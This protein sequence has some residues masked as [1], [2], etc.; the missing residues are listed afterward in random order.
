MFKDQDDKL[1][2]F[3]DFN[4][5]D[6]EETEGS[7][8]LNSEDLIEETTEDMLLDQD[9]LETE[10]VDGNEFSNSIESDSEESDLIYEDTEEFSE[11]SDD[12]ESA[13]VGIPEALKRDSED[14]EE[15]DDKKSKKKKNK[16]KKEKKKKKV[17][18]KSKVSKLSK[19]NFIAKYL[20]VMKTNKDDSDLGLGRNSIK[21]QIMTITS[22]AIIVPMVLIAIVVFLQ[23][24]NSNQN[25]IETSASV[26]VYQASDLIDE[27][28]ASMMNILPQTFRELSAAPEQYGILT[29]V[30]TDVLRRTKNSSP[31]IYEAYLVSHEDYV[32]SSS[33][34]NMKASDELLS[35]DWF[36][37]ARNKTQTIWSPVYEDGKLKYR[38]TSKVTNSIGQSLFVLEIDM[39][40]L[41]TFAENIQVLEEG[42]AIVASREGLILYHPNAELIGQTLPES[43]YEKM[44]IRKEYVNPAMRDD[45]GVKSSHV[46]QYKW[47]LEGSDDRILTYTQN[48]GVEWVIMTTFEKSEIIA[49]IRPIF[50]AIA[51]VI[52]LVLFIFLSLG[53]LVANRITS[54]ISQLIGIMKQVEDGDLSVEFETSAKSEVKILGNSFNVMILNLRT[55]VGSMKNTFGNVEDFVNTLTTA[56]EQTSLASEEISKS[57]ISVAEGAETQADK[58]NESV[59]MIND[60]DEKILAVNDSAQEIKVSSSDAIELN[61]E[62]ISLV[63]DLKDISE[64]N[65]EKAEH[66]IT[67]MDTLSGRVAKIS[68][69]ISLINNISRQ[70]NLL[71][72]NAS[73]E[74]ARAGEHGRGFAVVANEVSKLAEE[75]SQAVQGIGSLLN[76]I[77]EDVNKASSAID[78][79]QVIATKQNVQVDASMKIF[80]EISTWINDIVIKVNVIETDLQA[81]VSSKDTVATSI[82]TISDLAQDSSAVSEEVSAAT[83]EQ[84]ASLEQLDS[85]TREL[86]EMVQQASRDISEQFKL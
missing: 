60:M 6:V 38:V 39:S 69:I 77:S 61:A 18:D 36:I 44:D 11:E 15:T 42:Y 41:L 10:Y 19:Y 14:T 50:I 67:E 5:S 62:G 70:T 7:E 54:P 24:T 30:Y 40:D 65:L 68:D 78:T 48:E 53:Y 37:E 47:D 16:V 27:K 55:I 34:I 51:I 80:D 9:T 2:E 32:Y 4:E 45:I 57:M 76:E 83:E 17:K 28:V 86:N 71:A 43:L 1:E 21:S 82:N 72:L 79:M 29:D 33:G 20:K 75:T 13:E 52:V 85:N 66:V 35:S 12:L 73:I 84:L 31:Y 46:T 81:A 23:V 64:E 49:K 74:A 8:E 26:F 25:D 22:M 3:V 58:T 59:R 56:V 63:T